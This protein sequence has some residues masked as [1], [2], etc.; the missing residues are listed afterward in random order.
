VAGD[1]VRLQNTGVI[2]LI[3]GMDFSIIEAGDNAPNAY[4]FS[5]DLFGLPNGTG[6]TFRRVRRDRHYPRKRFIVPLD[7]NAGITQATN[8]VVS[9]S[10]PHDFTV[11]ERVTLRVANEF[12]MRE[13]NNKSATV[14]STTDFTVTL[15][16]DTTGFNPFV[17]TAATLLNAKATPPQIIPSGTTPSPGANPPIVPTQS[18]SDDRDEVILSMGSEVITGINQVYDWMAYKYDETI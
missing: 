9:C 13:A 2:G 8:A 11:G 10:V 4:T 3:D 12:G 7:G 6:G 16:L 17:F 5:L 14:L 18:A 15:D 1:V